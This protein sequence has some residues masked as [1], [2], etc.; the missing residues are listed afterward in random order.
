M[1]DLTLTAEERERY[2][3]QMGPG[4][5]SLA[6]QQR[7]KNSAALITRVGGMGGPAAQMLTMAGVGRVIIAHGGE[8]ISPDLNRQVLGSEAVLGEPRA[9]HF[10]QYLRSLNRFVEVEGLPRE[11]DDAEAAAL[12]ARCNLI[13]SCPPTFTERLRLSR[14]AEQ[15]NL[16]FID[17]A[18]WGMT[19][20]LMVFHPDKKPYLERVYPEPPEFEEL[21]P[22]VGAI[23]AAIGALAAL[24]AIKILSGEGKPIWN[25]MLIY[26]GFQGRVN[27]VEI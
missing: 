5:L 15:A 23:S 25:Q 16:P 9:P 11:P 6:G 13:V 4:V 2:A 17:A 20:S 1:T 22:V 21:F 3:R 19:G 24:E 8:L 14:A 10:A 27:Q 7:L 18:Q 12:A 26:D